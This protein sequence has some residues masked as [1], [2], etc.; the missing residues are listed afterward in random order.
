MASD[1]VVSILRA[2]ITELKAD[3]TKG[4]AEF[5]AF[6]QKV[7]KSVPED[8][9]ARLKADVADLKQVTGSAG[10]ALGGLAAGGA[11]LTKSFVDKAVEM[12]QFRGTLIAVTKDVAVADAQLQKMVD[13]AASTPF[14]LPG[15]VSAGVQLTSLRQNVDRFLPLA[16][17]LAAVFGRDI[18]DAAQ[19]L[20]KALAGSQDGL[21]ILAD[22][23]GIS[24]REMAQFGAVAKADG[25]I[26]ATT[27][28]ELEKLAN[29]LEKIIK[30]KYGGAMEAQSKTAAGAF[31]NLSDAID[32][33]QASLGAEVADDFAKLAKGI[34]G[35]VESFQA[36][37]DSTKRMVAQSIVLATGVA[38]VTAALVGVAAV[39]GPVAAGLATLSAASAG[40]MGVVGT[41]ASGLLLTEGAITA[42]AGAAVAGSSGMAA[43]T[44]TTAA[45]GTAAAAAGTGFAGFAAIAGAALVP[46][47]VLGT[48]AFAY[49][50]HRM[51]EANQAAEE[52]RAGQQ[53]V[54]DR[55]RES[56]EAIVQAADALRDYNGNIEAA[57]NAT[58][59][60]FKETGKT[61]LDAAKSIL[62]LNEARNK[63]WEDGDNE[64]AK[65]LS[66]R[67]AVMYGVRQQLSG[68]HV[69]KMEAEKKAA[70]AAKAALE[71]QAKAE[72]TYQKR[73]TA[74]FYETKKAQLE[75]LDAV[76]IGAKQG[77]KE[78]EALELSRIK[79]VREAS[80]EEIAGDLH[81]IDLRKKAGELS[82]R[83]EVAA[84]QAILKAKAAILEVDERQR[85]ESEIAAANGKIKADN[86]KRWADAAKKSAEAGK[87]AAEESFALQGKGLQTELEATKKLEDRLEI[88]KKLVD[89]EAQ[90]ATY[91][92]KNA[93]NRRTI[94]DNAKAEKD[95]LDKQAAEAIEKRDTELASK[96]AELVAQQVADED[97]AQEDLFAKR[98]RKLDEE[99]ARGKNVYGERLRLEQDE[100]EYAMAASEKK[101][102]AVEAEIEAK[103][104][105]ADAGAT[106]EEQKIN[107]DTAA[108]EL[109]KAERDASRQTQEIFDKSNATLVE[110]TKHLREQL[111]LLRKQ[112]EE[113]KDPTFSGEAYG[114]EGLGEN[115]AGWGISRKKRGQVGENGM[116][117]AEM[118]AEIARNEGI[119]G[120]RQTYRDKTGQLMPTFGVSR[121]AQEQAAAEAAAAP[122]N[123]TEQAAKMISLV[124]SI[125]RSVGAMG[126][127][128]GKS[129]KGSG[130]PALG[131]APSLYPNTSF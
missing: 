57:V 68:T 111:E 90:K 10:V 20:G 45:A 114:A 77:S 79:L 88:E 1:N 62:A 80:K 30:S 39:V 35:A 18:K 27:A 56:R 50:I 122:R 34:T 117:E 69:E 64:R 17:D 126:S 97:A 22:S 63:A 28:P 98:R 109:R 127:N 12:Q 125:A 110:R 59:N 46:A 7:P 119:L 83:Q 65:I 107:A 73:A 84:L 116:T 81:A 78:R 95:L 75:A 61:D 102:A 3:L 128:L 76:L 31:S 55:F 26:A 4:I 85:I 115:R 40:V 51:G 32:Q 16:G 21:T 108:L 52:L 13:F 44:G 93:K 25:S 70:D 104:K 67:I 71:A 86:E 66:D 38:G 58:A 121:S 129:G 42:A 60:S 99:A 14:D 74:G 29:A 8:P 33:L 48:A 15:V 112:K 43:L 36:M 92:E 24:K 19:A 41:L 120:N 87:K 6:G 105:A 72:E 113:A 5:R 23:F 103:R 131:L 49:L 124:E 118:K 11:A 53:K 2:N 106:P 123:Q 96:R 91:G 94:L 9:F 37:P 82:A 100:L 89:L 130:S 47:L 101:L 54:A